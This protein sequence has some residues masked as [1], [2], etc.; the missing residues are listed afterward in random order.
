VAIPV[1]RGRVAPRFDHAR[2]GW[3]FTLSPRGYHDLQVLYW[4]AESE[5]ERVRQLR[6]T[7]VRVLICGAIEDW[8]LGYVRHWGMVGIPW[9][10]GEVYTVLQKFLQ[11][12][13]WGQDPR[14]E[15]WTRRFTMP[16]GRGR[17]Q[18]PGPKGGGGPGRGGGRAGGFGAGPGG[19]C[20][21]PACGQKV[22][23]QL[24]VPCFEVKCPQ[25]GTAMTRER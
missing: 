11:G 17:G 6:Q 7:G 4:G 3:V 25:C 21:C 1:F 20:I 12:C 14:L 19:F 23:H 10:Q 24:G 18:G 9:V 15:A 8:L 16:D 22:P 13:W 5:A 2:E